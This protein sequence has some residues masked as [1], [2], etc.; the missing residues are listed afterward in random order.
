MHYANIFLPITLIFAL[1]GVVFSHISD[2]N[3]ITNKN[4]KF[5]TYSTISGSIGFGFA[6]VMM[7][8]GE[9][10][11]S[12]SASLAIPI[13]IT[14]GIFIGSLTGAMFSLLAYNK[15]R[16]GKN[17]EENNHKHEPILIMTFSLYFASIFASIFMLYR[18]ISQSS[19]HFARTSNVQNEF[20]QNLG[21]DQQDDLKFGS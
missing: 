1:L 19:G 16:D 9:F 18:S 6:I 14:F 20:E 12:T 4:Y 2:R 13:M 15:L 8:I 10:I 5:L 3:M 11:S 7:I 21:E 17:W